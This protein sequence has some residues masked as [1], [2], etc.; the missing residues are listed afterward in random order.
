MCGSSW[1]TVR[2]DVQTKDTF[3]LGQR[4]LRRIHGFWQLAI[5]KQ[6]R[7]SIQSKREKESL[8]KSWRDDT[9]AKNKIK[10]Q[11]E[12]AASFSVIFICNRILVS[13][14]SILQ[15]KPISFFW[16]MFCPSGWFQWECMNCGIHGIN[17]GLD[18]SSWIRNRYC[19]R[20]RRRR[21][22]QVLPTAGRSCLKQSDA[23]GWMG[24]DFLYGVNHHL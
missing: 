17:E 19:G 3:E 7:D 11:N 21:R 16:G 15:T 12:H 8:S 10:E 13:I 24:Y 14:S 2:N 22:R 1:L 5:R 6:W 20:R 23:F 18:T 9:R 4:F